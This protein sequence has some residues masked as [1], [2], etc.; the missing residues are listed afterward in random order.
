MLTADVAGLD[1]LAGPER[2]LPL[3][4]L[5]GGAADQRAAQLAARLARDRI[6]NAQATLLSSGSNFAL[7]A[8]FDGID[9]ARAQADAA[10][11]RL[12]LAG[13]GALAAFALFI[14]LAAGALRADQHADVERL[15]M[16]G[17]RNGQC[18]LFV[19]AE[20][21]WLCAIAVVVGACVGARG[22]GRARPRRG[23]P[24]GRGAHAQPADA[25]RPA[26]ARGRLGRAPRRL[27][28]LALVGAG[29]RGGRRSPRSRRP[30]R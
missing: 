21:A 24:R 25:G 1:A 2:H 19:V 13:G 15:R 6:Q 26:R 16:A 22:R 11:S 3:P 30:R 23:R 10:P 27:L 7:S 18:A 4:Q 20:S 28:S 5:A 9:Q 17:A 8:P 12:L 14:V 29:A